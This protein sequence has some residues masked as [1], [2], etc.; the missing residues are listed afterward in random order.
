MPGSS[1]EVSRAWISFRHGSAEMNPLVSLR[2]RVRSLTLLS[3]FGI[4]CGH[5]LSCRSQTWL[6]SCVAVA[7]VQASSCNSDSTP[8]LETSICHGYGPKKKKKEYGPQQLWVPW[9]GS[10]YCGTRGSAV[11]LVCWDIG[12]IPCPA[13]WIKDPAQL[14]HRLQLWLRSDP[15]PGNSIYHRAAKKEKKEAK[16]N[17]TKQNKKIN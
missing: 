17:T 16:E 12:S 5:E 7:V 11:S 9:P 14:W 6:R 13:Q 1:L 3:G 2:I 4:Q 8:S 15:W 10:S